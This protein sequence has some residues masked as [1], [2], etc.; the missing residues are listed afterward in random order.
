IAVALFLLCAACAIA[1]VVV[2]PQLPT[3]SATA[4]AALGTATP[5]ITPTPT[6][7]FTPTPTSTFT[8]TP[9]LTPSATS[10]PVVADTATPTVTPTRTPT[11]NRNVG[12]V[13]AVLAADTIQVALAGQVVTVKY[14]AIEV[15][16]P[17][18][19]F[20][21][22]AVEINKLLVEGQTV[23]LEQDVT[24][25]DDAGNL[26]R[27]VYVGNTQI[28]EEMLR[29]GVAKFVFSPPDT[30]YAARLQEVEQAARLNKI[31]LWSLE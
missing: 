31:G 14:L 2:G 10:T 30:K 25:R 3:L 11:P 22:E 21:P 6:A 27:Y 16:A 19:P 18:A 13:V 8:P 26:L 24:N 17:D 5:T 29:Q 7:T 12:Q 20:G 1:A 15:P 28:N 9:T 4:D 23:R